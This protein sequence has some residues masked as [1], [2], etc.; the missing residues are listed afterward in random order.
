MNQCM[1]DIAGSPVDSKREVRAPANGH[2]PVTRAY[3]NPEYIIIYHHVESELSLLELKKQIKIQFF[4]NNIPY[5]V[6]EP[7][8]SINLEAGCCHVAT[9]HGCH[10]PGRLWQFAALQ[11]GALAGHLRLRGQGNIG[12]L[13]HWIDIQR[14]WG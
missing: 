4:R 8:I 14:G 13:D 10:A 1:P 5:K 9:K 12:P 2:R 11:P 6:A 3:T 7:G